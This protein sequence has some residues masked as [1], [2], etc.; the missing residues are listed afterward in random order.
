MGAMR[1]LFT[2][3]FALRESFVHLQAPKSLNFADIERLLCSGVLWA[4]PV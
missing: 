1:S 4:I 2:L 3:E